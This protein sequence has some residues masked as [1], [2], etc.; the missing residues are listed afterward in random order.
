MS[1]SLY[2]LVTLCVYDIWETKPWCQSQ[3]V[4]K[5]DL[6]TVSGYHDIPGPNVSQTKNAT[7]QGPTRPSVRAATN[8]F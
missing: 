8:N 3:A 4:Y 6:E 7:P 1:G 5:L 2:L